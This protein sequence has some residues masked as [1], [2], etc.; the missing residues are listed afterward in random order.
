[1]KKGVFQISSSPPQSIISENKDIEKRLT[2]KLDN[3]LQLGDKV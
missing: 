1:M 2:E 3:D